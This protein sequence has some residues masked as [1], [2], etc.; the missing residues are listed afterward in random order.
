ML[1]EE[2]RDYPY[3][4]LVPWAGLFKGSLRELGDTQLAFF[5]LAWRRW[6]YRLTAEVFE[7]KQ[8]ENGAGAIRCWKTTQG[9]EHCHIPLRLRENHG[10][11]LDSF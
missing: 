6:K 8:T 2:M 11:K 5:V 3:G 10:E 4:R 9:Q 1:G 7:L